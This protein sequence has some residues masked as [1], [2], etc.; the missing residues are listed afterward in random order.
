LKF[1][2]QRKQEK[3]KPAVMESVPDTFQKKGKAKAQVKRR[4]KKKTQQ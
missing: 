3:M 1:Q 2:E 4:A